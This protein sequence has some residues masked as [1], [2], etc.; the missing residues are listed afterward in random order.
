VTALAP[1]ILRVGRRPGE[2]R[3][4][5]GPEGG[6]RPPVGPALRPWRN[7][8]RLLRGVN[9]MAS[10]LGRRSGSCD[11]LLSGHSKRIYAKPSLCYRMA[12]NT[13][14]SVKCSPSICQA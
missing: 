8:S 9:R 11:W 3:V 6:R 2:R 14:T 1:P 10:E 5:A 7:L 13:I 12:W 4:A